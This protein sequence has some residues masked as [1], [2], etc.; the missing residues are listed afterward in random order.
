MAAGAV[1]GILSNNGETT[2]FSFIVPMAG[3]TFTVT[4]IGVDF[5]SAGASSNSGTYTYSGDKT[6]L[7]L[8]TSV[9]ATTP[10]YTIGD[11]FEGEQTDTD[12]YIVEGEKEP[13]VTITYND[14]VIASLEAGQ[15]ATLQCNGKKMVSDVIVT[16]PEIT[17]SPSPIEI[18]TEA[19]MTALLET[20]EIGSVY[21]YTGETTDTYENG[22]LYIVEAATFSLILSASYSTST[23]AGSITYIKLNSQP[24]SNSD[25]EHDSKSLYE[26]GSITV[27]TSSYWYWTS[28]GDYTSAKEVVLTEDTSATF[29]YI[30]HIGGVN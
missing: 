9:N 20:A 2:L 7:G 24:T 11:T 26:N 1:S 10:T 8:A 6:F 5:V 27:Q 14:N 15:T 29:S 18:P 19:E 22:A 17:D 4:A 23:V 12:Y 30:Q 25:Y 16:T 3:G 13:K 21:K 28:N